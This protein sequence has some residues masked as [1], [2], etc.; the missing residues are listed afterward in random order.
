MIILLITISAQDPLINLGGLLET[1]IEG[2]LGGV[3]FTGILLIPF[4]II[5]VIKRVIAKVHLSKKK[6]GKSDNNFEEASEL[7]KD[8]CVKRETQ[9]STETDWDEDEIKAIEDMLRNK[10]STRIEKQKISYQQEHSSKKSVKH[11]IN[12][13]K[14]VSGI[15]LVTLIFI[16]AAIFSGMFNKSSSSL[17]MTVDEFSTSYAQTDAYKAINSYG[18]AFPAV[19]LDQEAVTSGSAATSDVRTFSNIAVDN[20]VNYQVTLSGSINKTDANIQ[21]LHVMMRLSTRAA[22][23]EGLVIYAPYIQVLY[24]DMT[25]KEAN[26]FLAELYTNANYVTAKGKYE[27]YMKT[28]TIDKM[29]YCSLNISPIND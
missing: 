22:L 15:V 8:I 2:F 4:I 12:P 29:F 25:T 1:V 9:V 28:G 13:I 24:P 6:D 23:K 11:R 21:A 19:S 18:F 26:S 3:L 17:G 14:V 7:Y 27:L 10:K 5:A 16:V 20:T